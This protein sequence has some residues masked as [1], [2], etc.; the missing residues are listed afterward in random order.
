MAKDAWRSK[1]ARQL[2]VNFWKD[3]QRGGKL[4]VVSM[5]MRENYPNWKL[6]EKECSSINLTLHTKELFKVEN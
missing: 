5:S 2:R 4:E 3:S 1:M 6:Q